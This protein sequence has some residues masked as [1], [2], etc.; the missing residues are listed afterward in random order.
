MAIPGTVPFNTL[1]V[2]TSVPIFTGA[3]HSANGGLGRPL[4]GHSLKAKM[5]TLICNN[6]VVNL[7]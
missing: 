1:T 6:I 3:L 2:S 7:E 4:E 5:S